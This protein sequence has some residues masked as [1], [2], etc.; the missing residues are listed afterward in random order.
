MLKERVEDTDYVIFLPFIGVVPIELAETYPF[1]QFVFSEIL[2]LEIMERA[3]EEVNK[4]I[5]KNEYESIKIS[6]I[7]AIEISEELKILIS[8]LFKGS[9]KNVKLI[10]L[11]EL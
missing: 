1:S 4:F 8:G 10:E 11:A 6:S 9:S 2:T 3:K 7:D 5:T